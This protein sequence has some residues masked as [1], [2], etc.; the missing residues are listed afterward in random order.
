[1]E[2][3][4]RPSFLTS[5]LLLPKLRRGSPRNANQRHALKG[6]PRT[7]GEAE[8]RAGVPPLLPSTRHDRWQHLPSPHTPRVPITP[9]PRTEYHSRLLIWPTPDLSVW[10]GTR[11]EWCLRHVLMSLLQERPQ[12][13]CLAIVAFG[14]RS[15]VPSSQYSKKRWGG[16]QTV[17]GLE[18][19]GGQN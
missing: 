6:S 14:V 2:P 11:D 10:L 16:S 15:N 1:M 8:N 12:S 7:A 19:S 17:K 5:T 9:S 13:R 18:I 3:G 4:L